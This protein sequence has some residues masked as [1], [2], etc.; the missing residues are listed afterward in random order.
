[1]GCI[2]LEFIVWLLY[3]FTALR[4]FRGARDGVRENAYYRIKAGSN[5]QDG[6][7]RG[8]EVHPEVREAVRHLKADGRC[9][10]TALGALVRLVESDIL[11]IVPED[12]L[13]SVELHGKLKNMLKDAEEDT[14]YLFNAADPP[15]P[16]PET[17]S[18][19]PPSLSAP[20]ST[21]GHP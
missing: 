20:Q 7:K 2:I 13:Q 15:F 19:P 17:F 5:T 12:R 21:H 10:G 14:L 11:K 6:T 18:R 1:M 9:Q 3:D 16:V 8:I 4:S